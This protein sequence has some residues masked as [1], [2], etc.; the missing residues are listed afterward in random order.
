[1]PTF[2]WLIVAMPAILIIE[3]AGIYRE[4]QGIYAMFAADIPRSLYRGYTILGHDAPNRKADG[5]P[6]R[7]TGIVHDQEMAAVFQSRVAGR[8]YWLSFQ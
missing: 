3:T 8:I 4:Q 1:M 5:T 7:G 6:L 2:L